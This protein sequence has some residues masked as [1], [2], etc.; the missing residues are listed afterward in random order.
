MDRGKRG[1]G[2]PTSE[3]VLSG[4]VSFYDRVAGIRLERNVRPVQDVSVC[5]AVAKRGKLRGED[6]DATR[7]EV[8]R[9]PSDENDSEHYSHN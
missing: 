3:L 5:L 6:R 4:V 2:G 8:E 9:A 7:G 1:T